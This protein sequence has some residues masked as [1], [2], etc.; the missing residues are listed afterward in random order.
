MDLLLHVVQAAFVA[1]GFFIGVS[2]YATKYFGYLLASL[3]FCGAGIVSYGLESWWVLLA[4]Y[5]VTFF[6]RLAGFDRGPDSDA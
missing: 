2:F 5:V 1:W 4:G 6:L 3:T